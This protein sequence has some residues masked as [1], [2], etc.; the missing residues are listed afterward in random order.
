MGHRADYLSE[1]HTMK[2]FSKEL[3]IPSNVIDRGS[4]DAWKRK[5]AKTTFERASERADQLVAKYQQPPFSSEVCAE[6][7][8]ITKT[9]A[10][11]FGMEHLPPLT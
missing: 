8:N 11:K 9:A 2:W 5:G 7:R 10:R 4:L 3:H 6:I 1:M